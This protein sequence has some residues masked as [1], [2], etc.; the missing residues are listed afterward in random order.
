MITIKQL[1]DKIKWDVNLKKE[2]FDFFYLDREE[3]K[4]FK[5]NFNDIKKV[6]NN[7]LELEEKTIPLHRIKIVK[8]KGK[9][10][11]QRMF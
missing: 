1:I 7:V 9:T 6:Y 10:I 11:W 8:E 5:F 3:G 4:L 2:N